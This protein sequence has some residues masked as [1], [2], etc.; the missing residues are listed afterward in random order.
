VH[1]KHLK[2][3][4]QVKGLHLGHIAASFGLQEQ[5]SAIGGSGAAKER[6]RRK[7][8]ARREEVVRKK[9]KMRSSARAAV[10]GAR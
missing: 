1:P 5:P 7:A 3:I 10:A 8:E 6:K 2:P 4:F 9:K